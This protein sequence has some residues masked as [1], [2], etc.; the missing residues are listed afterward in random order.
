MYSFSCNSQ[1]KCFRTHVDMDIFLVL[2]MWNS[3][4]KFSLIFQLHSVHH[5]KSE[6]KEVWSYCMPREHSGHFSCE[7][8]FRI[9]MWHLWLYFLHTHFSSTSAVAWNGGSASGKLRWYWGTSVGI[10]TRL[11]AG[12]PGFDSQR[13][14]EICS[15]LYSR[16]IGCGTHPIS[17]TMGT[18]SSIPEVKRQEREA[19]HSPPHSIEVKNCRAIPPLPHTPSWHGA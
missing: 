12:W 1:I 5:L 9:L 4:T 18:W 10:A 8:H 13:G 3:C 2:V 15:V 6:R 11:R 14:Q 7:H 16:Q 19:D 17:C